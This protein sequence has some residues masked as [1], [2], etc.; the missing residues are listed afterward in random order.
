MNNCLLRWHV[1]TSCAPDSHFSLRHVFIIAIAATHR[2]GTT[3][4]DFP[5]SVQLAFMT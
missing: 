1:S 4:A 5:L 2:C 3:L